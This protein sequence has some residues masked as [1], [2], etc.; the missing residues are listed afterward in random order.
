MLR[1]APYGICSP[2]RDPAN[3]YRVIDVARR[4]SAVASVE[5]TLKTRTGNYSRRWTDTWPAVGPVVDGC[6][7]WQLAPAVWF[8]E[9][10]RQERSRRSRR[11]TA[12]DSGAGLE[13]SASGRSPEDLAGLTSGRITPAEPLWEGYGQNRLQLLASH[14]TALRAA[15]FLKAYAEAS[16]GL[17]R[18][19][20]RGRRALRVPGKHR[21][22]WDGSPPPPDSP[23]QNSE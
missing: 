11:T 23:V 1:L 22:H 14:G 21:D 7:L 5:P 4:V 18:G 10:H 3:T 20:G 2:A 12:A 9:L 15:S 17:V 6:A 19:P 16:V 8:T 13:V